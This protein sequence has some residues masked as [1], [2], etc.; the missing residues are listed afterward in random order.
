MVATDSRLSVTS[1]SSDTTNL[2]SSLFA[3][4]RYDG[5]VASVGFVEQLRP[6]TRSLETTERIGIP[7]T[8]GPM[9]P[10]EGR[11]VWSLMRG[12]LL[13]DPQLAF[14][15]R[16]WYARLCRW[17]VPTGWACRAAGVGAQIYVAKSA[18]AI[19]GS[20]LSTNF[21]SLGFAGDL[22]YFGHVVVAPRVRGLGVGSQLV[23]DALRFER[24]GGAGRALLD[25]RADNAPAVRL[26][27]RAG[28]REST[29]AFEIEGGRADSGPVDLAWAGLS[30]ELLRDL[31]RE[32][33]PEFQGAD[34]RRLTWL[35][36]FG[37]RSIHL[38]GR[39]S[40][41]LEQGRPVA[42][43]TDRATNHRGL[44]AVRILPRCP[45]ARYP[46][47]VRAARMLGWAAQEPRPRL[48]ISGASAEARRIREAAHALGMSVA[49]ETIRM[50]C[51]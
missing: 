43:L 42:L 2:P 50:V 33:F 35:G 24:D 14:P 13:A 31:V 1:P 11:A 47:V 39:S 34:L 15:G 22:R 16:R 7:A 38:L 44:R 27:L 4:A 45:V 8:V 17:Y 28:F 48:V 29:R 18:G 51:G 40:V 3:P 23:Q 26:Y 19:V 9:R 5:G 10:T 49:S 6:A 30:M 37:M 46:T 21:T 36:D 32:E 20:L 12:A 25:V 41:L